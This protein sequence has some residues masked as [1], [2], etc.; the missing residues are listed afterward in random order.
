[1]TTIHF[2]RS[3]GLL[4][5]DINIDL[6][7]ARLP[8]DE[9]QTL[10]NLIF[11]SEFFELPENLNGTS[12]PDEFQYVITIRSGQSEHTVHVNDTTMPSSLSPLVAALSVVHAISDDSHKKI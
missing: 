1:M 6:D 11:Q 9:A 3:G 4:G 10:Q 7:L 12:T 8:D 2:E 5:D